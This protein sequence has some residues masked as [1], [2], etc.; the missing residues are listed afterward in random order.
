M[1]GGAFDED[2]AAS[3]WPWEIVDMLAKAINEVR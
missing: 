1:A 2:V 3:R